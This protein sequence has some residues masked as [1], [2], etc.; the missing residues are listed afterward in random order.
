MPILTVLV[1]LPALGAALVAL[2]LAGLILGGASPFCRG[3]AELEL[4]GTFEA[5]GVI[6]TVEAGDD[7]EQDAEARLAYR[8]SGDALPSPPA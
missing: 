5:M 6:V 4:Y 3:A 1:V 2:V 7:P 8:L